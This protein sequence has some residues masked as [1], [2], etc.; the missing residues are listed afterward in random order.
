MLQTESLCQG[1]NN[2]PLPRAEIRAERRLVCGAICHKHDKLRMH[3]ECPGIGMIDSDRLFLLLGKKVGVRR[4]VLR[5][6]GRRRRRV[7]LGGLI[8]DVLLERIFK[9]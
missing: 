6:V 8:P 7:G 1:V 5:K 4:R 2:L 9:H 3:V